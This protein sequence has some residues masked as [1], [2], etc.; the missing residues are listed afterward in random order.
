MTDDELCNRLQIELY[1]ASDEDAELVTKARRWTRSLMT[2]LNLRRRLRLAREAALAAGDA[3][4]AEAVRETLEAAVQG[5]V[6]W[7]AEALDH[8]EVRFI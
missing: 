1:Q 2:D 6:G 5:T 3:H 7:Q 4:K 8:L